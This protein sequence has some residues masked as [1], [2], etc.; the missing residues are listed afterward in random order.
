VSFQE[1]GRLW[2]WLQ[3]FNKLVDVS[4]RI[5]VNLSIGHFGSIFKHNL[6]KTVLNPDSRQHL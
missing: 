5:L 4:E 6:K 1:R 3:K 2:A